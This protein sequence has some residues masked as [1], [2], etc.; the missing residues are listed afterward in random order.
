MVTVYAQWWTLLLGTILP[1]VVALV[2]ARW[3]SSRLGALLLVAL[4]VVTAVAA[5]IV[6][7]SVGDATFS[8]VD[9][10]ERFVLLFVVAVVAHFGLLKPTGITGSDGV[11]ERKVPGGIGDTRTVSEPPPE[12]GLL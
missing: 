3:G 4:S 2:R 9:V 12:D 6:V 1:A 11:I 5:E 10:G 7:D 8:W